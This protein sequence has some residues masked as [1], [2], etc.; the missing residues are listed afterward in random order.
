MFLQPH[1]FQQHDLYGD[2]RLRYHLARIDPFHWGVREVA[3]DEDAL[4]KRVVSLL[5][6]DVVLPGGLRVLLDADG[7]SIAA[8]EFKEGIQ[9]LDVHVGVRYWSDT[10]GN[11]GDGNGSRPTRFRLAEEEVPDLHRGGSKTLVQ[12]STPDARLFLSGEE[13]ELE[14]YDSFRLAV[15]E[16]S[17]S[18]DRPFRLRKTYAPPLL[19]IQAW[20][21]LYDEVVSIVS[22][23]A[24]KVRVVAGRT[25]TIAVAD[26]PR[27]WMRYTLARMAPVLR[28]LL[29]TGETQPYAIYT[30]LI[31]TAGALSAFHQNEAIEIPDYDHE[32][33]YTCFS[34]LL[35]LI[36]AELQESVPDRFTELALP[37]DATHKAYA[38]GE[39]TVELADP[40]NVFFLAIKA[41]LDAK[42]LAD[43]VVSQ[44]KAGSRESVKNLALLNVKGLRIEHMPAAPTEIAARAGYEYFRVDPHGSQWSKVREEFAF[45][46]NLGKLEGADARLYV[47]QGAV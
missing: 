44:G 26:L 37:F 43:L 40:R 20:P 36:D 17:G 24:A 25:A 35:R 16:A 15:V 41:S 34:N 23:I 4:S 42:E 11:A 32:D 31:E 12:F 1:H 3:F 8:R 27:M 6:L 19:A 45:G 47:V 38:T 39:L 18:T 46:I 9:E 5:H 7:S 21:A 33:L 29:A 2:E 30:A 10:E 13:A 22:Q 28:H 14:G